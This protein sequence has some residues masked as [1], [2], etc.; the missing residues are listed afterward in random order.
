MMDAL[1]DLL[2]QAEEELRY[3]MTAE[4]LMALK[5]KYLGRKGLLTG[6]LRN[7]GRIPPEE[8][9]LFGK[10]SNEVKEILLARFDGALAAATAS[11]QETR[12]QKERIDVTLPGRGIPFG[13]THP[14][15][16]VC[17]E[18]CA[19]FAQLGFSIVEGPEIETDYY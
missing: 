13:H 17:R 3:A 9:P 19:I 14:V 16:Q 7:I 6:I 11:D 5:V 4:A 18:I 1:D 12:I 2:R 8:R 15:T 10:R